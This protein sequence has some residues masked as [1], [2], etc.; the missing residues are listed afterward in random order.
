MPGNRFSRGFVVGFVVLVGIGLVIRDGPKQSLPE[1]APGLVA[2][3]VGQ[4]AR[5]R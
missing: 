2:S 5:R 4:R 1:Q 3:R